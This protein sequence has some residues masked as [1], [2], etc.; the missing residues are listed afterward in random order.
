MEA[1]DDPPPIGI[2]M[3]VHRPNPEFLRKQVESIRAQTHAAWTLTMVL[4]GVHPELEPLLADWSAADP[5]IRSITVPGHAGCCRT[6]GHALAT[7]KG[8]NGL[9]A[10]ADQDDIWEPEKLAKLAAV[11]RRHPDTVMAFCDSSV[12]DEQ[13][14]PVSPSLTHAERRVLSF[15]LASLMAR[16]CISGHAQ[17]FRASLLDH[18]VPFPDGLCESGLNHDHWIALA[19]SLTGPIRHLEEPLVR[20]RLHASNQIGPRLGARCGAKGLSAWFAQNLRLRGALRSRHHLLENL[21][22]YPH[23]RFGRPWLLRLAIRSLF[24]SNPRAAA[25]HLRACCATGGPGDNHPPCP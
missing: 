20:H 24:D 1:S 23:C 2:L 15:G 4:D 8:T 7:A 10:L 6:F 11:F 13:D 12:I 19:A 3:A 9:I 18:A 17:L 25:I 22:G 14:R 21:P 5:R 16:N